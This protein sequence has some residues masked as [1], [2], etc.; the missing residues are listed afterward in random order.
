MATREAVAIIVTNSV[1]L[2]LAGLSVGLRIYARHRNGN[3]LGPD[4]YF[5]A[6]ALVGRSNDQHKPQLIENR[7]FL[8]HWSLPSLLALRLVVL[9]RSS[10]T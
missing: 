5:I 1:F 7:H 3:A 8:R 6:G 10:K 9:E 2:V 4:D